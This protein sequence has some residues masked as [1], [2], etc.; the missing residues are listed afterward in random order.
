LASIGEIV[1]IYR[2]YAQRQGYAPKN[3]LIL[4]SHGGDTGSEYVYFDKLDGSRVYRPVQRW[5]QENEGHHD[6]LFITACNPA[7]R[8]IGDCS[9]CLIVYPNGV[10]YGNCMLDDVAAGLVSP[11][12]LGLLLTNKLATQGEPV[13]TI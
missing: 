6:A 7:K 13:E 9:P 4:I 2:G 8:I 3:P 1:D 10:F 12:D 5:V 11:E